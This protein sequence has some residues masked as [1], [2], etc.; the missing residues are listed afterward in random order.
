MR[1]S[2]TPLAFDFKGDFG[3]VAGSKK[4]FISKKRKIKLFK[5]RKKNEIFEYLSKNSNKFDETHFKEIVY[6]KEGF[7]SLTY[8]FKDYKY[9]KAIREQM[10]TNLKSCKDSS[11]LYHLIFYTEHNHPTNIK[12]NYYTLSAMMLSVLSIL[13]GFVPENYRTPSY[14][15]VMFVY[16]FILFI[17]LIV[18]GYFIG[19][20]ST[21]SY[22]NVLC[23]QALSETDY[24]E[25]NKI[26]TEEA[27]ATFDLFQLLEKLITWMK[28]K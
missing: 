6:S 18:S 24:L 26:I 11:L 28:I 12:N 3:E 21:Y 14:I 15:I 17:V 13:F 2:I 25:K 10:I 23:R 1:R 4:I 19:K 20:K 9:N 27:A 22:L 16:L 7:D 8:K 5:K